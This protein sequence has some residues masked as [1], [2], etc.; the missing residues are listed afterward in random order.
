[1]TISIVTL[2]FNQAAF[3]PAC[4]ASVAR[5]LRPGDEHLCVDPGS[6]DG[7]RQIIE[8]HAGVRPLFQPDRGPAEGLNH[9]FDAM[10]G[11]IGAFLNADDELAPGALD[12]VR[13]FFATRPDVDLLLGA[14][15]VIDEH[16][17]PALRKK[18][19]SRPS[20]AAVAGGTMA[21]YQQGLFFRSRVWRELRLRFNVQNRTCW[22]YEFFSDALIA[23]ARA[24]SIA[25]ELG[26]FRLHAASITGS[27]RLNDAYAKDR[28]RV[29]A[30]AAAALR[31]AG[32][33]GVFSAF[34]TKWDPLRRIAE[35]SSWGDA[36]EESCGESLAENSPVR[37]VVCWHGLPFYARRC[38]A[39]LVR[40]R[41]AWSITAVTDE[42]D[43]DAG[44]AARE[45]GCR[46]LTVRS[47]EPVTFSRLGSEVPDHLL[48][49]SW[50]HR[51]YRA[52]GRE[53]RRRGG[54]VT[55]LADN[56]FLGTARQ[57]AG[58]LYFRMLIR[59]DFD[60]V[61]VPG[62]SG[63]RFMAVMGVPQERIHTGLLAG[64]ET[65]F[66]PP[67]P[68][69][70]RSGVVYAGKLIPLK[71]V[72][73]L[74]RAWRTAGI[75]TPLTFVGGGGL[76]EILAAEGATLAGQVDAAGLARRLRAASAL[77]LVSRV[78]HWGLV[79][80]EAALCGCLLLV[81][82]TCGAA[83]DLV[84]HG[85]NGYVLRELTPQALRDALTWL[86]SLDENALA[87]GRALSVALAKRFSPAC[88]AGGVMRI[89]GRQAAERANIL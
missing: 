13:D 6:T 83:D 17:N 78:D 7:S 15:R 21:F 50:T 51:A 57:W 82:D 53:V 25:R 48:A 46:V 32:P 52:L 9:G 60:D 87:E 74:W 39:Q 8:T 30:E 58:A 62:K 12:C 26:R 75:Q 69:A 43:I 3:L 44:L 59:A 28:A 77:I 81:T 18:V 14:V 19:P 79:V 40:R 68:Q 67:E 34:A 88:W 16:G 10:R 38:I 86:E 89:V 80:H 2:S 23:R 36:P 73:E 76:A 61:W 66:S 85:K 27:G 54:A 64:D 71:R 33:A 70:L 4:I 1:M 29:E 49:T 37:L 56:C 84:V 11:D 31:D 72:V 22:D 65:V 5:Q 35:Y 24:V 55:M 63:R 45:C 41:P 42:L 47:G 20:L